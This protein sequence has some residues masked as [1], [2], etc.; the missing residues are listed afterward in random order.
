MLPWGW[1]ANG[2]VSWAE[3]AACV[4]PVS[5]NPRVNS[6]CVCSVLQ[7]DCISSSLK[8][9][10]WGSLVSFAYLTGC[11]VLG[12]GAKQEMQEESGMS[13]EFSMF[14]GSHDKGRAGKMELGEVCT[15]AM[16]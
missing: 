7:R 6:L 9:C 13:L 16:L 11:R 10:V 8:S 15:H 3:P 5:I 2:F 14:Q 12:D 4:A 1:L